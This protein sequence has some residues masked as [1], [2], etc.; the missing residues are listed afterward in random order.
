MEDT[1]SILNAFRVLLIAFI[2]TF[3]V[4]CVIGLLVFSVMT[5]LIG[6]SITFWQSVGLVYLTIIAGNLI[7]G[8]MKHGKS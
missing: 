1:P 8:E 3:L 6:V 5:Y 7:S 4:C 2:G